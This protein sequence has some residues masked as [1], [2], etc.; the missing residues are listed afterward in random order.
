MH[1]LIRQGTITIL[2]F[3]ML[4][5]ISVFWIDRELAIS[6]HSSRIDQLPILQFISNWFPT[7]ISI[8]F[9]AFLFFVRIKNNFGH[10]IILYIYLIILTYTAG[11]IKTGLKIIFGR[12][13]PKTWLNSNLSLINNNVFGF[14]WMQG[15][16]NQGSFPSGH[17]TFIAVTCVAMT[18]IYPQWI[19]LWVSLIVLMVASQVILDYHFLGDCFAGVALGGGCAFFGMALYLKFLRPKNQT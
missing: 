9:L 2:I 16:E 15:Y 1:H 11:Y 12:Y 19:K 7:S 8:F 13:W 10:R 18:I 14:N 4:A 3:S 17:S 6:I 5:F